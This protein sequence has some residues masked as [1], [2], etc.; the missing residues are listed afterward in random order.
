[1]IWLLIVIT[2]NLQTNPIE[3][4]HGEVIDTFHSH[5]D[6]QKKHTEFFET[7]KAEGQAIPPNFNLGCVVI[8][9]QHV[10]YKND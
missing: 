5:Q 9:I 10:S 7:A 4:Q 6:C 3:V 1:M 2:L 8:K